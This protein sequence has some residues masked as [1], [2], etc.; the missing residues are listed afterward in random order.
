MK[1]N[2]KYIGE[3]VRAA[4]QAKN[5]TLEQLA[6][7]IEIS[8]SFLGVAERGSSGFSTETIIKI[9]NALNVSA[10]SLLMENANT[11]TNPSDKLDTLITLM[12]NSSDDELD[13]FIDYIK[14]CK[15]RI[16]IKAK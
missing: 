9:A 2:F 4:R 3:N 14:L 15:G 12:K 10:D 16:E 8:E 1:E 11:A 5:L 7:I 13:F 6:E